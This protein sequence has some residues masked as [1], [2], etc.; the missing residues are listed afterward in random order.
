MK[1]II[2]LIALILLTNCSENQK[3]TSLIKSK[4]NNEIQ[5]KVNY[6]IETI[7][8]I[9]N[10]SE[11]GDFVL[12]QSNEDINYELI[13]LI[14]KHF[15]KFKNHQ[16]IL[17]FN[18]LNTLDLAHFNHYYYGLTF[19]ELPEFK[20][21]YPR[22]EEFYSS[23]RFNKQKVDSILTEFDTSIKSFY[24]EAEVEKYLN[25]NKEI[26]NAIITEI[27]LN[28]PENILPIM[29]K[30]FKSY[31]NNYVIVPSISI[32]IN[33]NFGTELKSNNKITYNYITG[34]Y[35]DLKI[36][37]NALS[38]ISGTDSLG[39]G[40]KKA[41]LDLAIHEFGHSFVRFIDKK[42]NEA[43]YKN[44]S[45]LNN[46][47][48]K[49]NFEKIGEGTEWNTI[50]E[51]H[52]VRANEIMIWREMGRTEMADEKLEYE[53]NNEGILYIKEFVKS[54]EKYRVNKKKYISFEE[55]FPK[56]ITDLKKINNEQ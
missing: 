38:E 23:K 30:Y 28:L 42:E 39:F 19:S 2:Y 33:W 14:R 17:L 22:Y 9:L 27:K 53:Y 21:I 10:L 8:I 47:Q 11:L 36:K 12:R 31:N 1:K 34:P 46:E 20:M 15:K 13:R 44:L 29:E 16:A 7:G 48:L 37:P 35:H 40:D 24:R 6:N 26:Y 50:F 52:L 18:K 49:N 55:Y 41:I 5:V 54:L 3:N 56:L 51:E 43:L 4:T 32:P 45:Y 25:E